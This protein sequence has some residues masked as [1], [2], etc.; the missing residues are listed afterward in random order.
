MPARTSG[1]T[2]SHP[3]NAI[4]AAIKA[5]ESAFQRARNLQ[6]KRAG[7]RRNEART[8]RLSKKGG[9][10]RK[11]GSI[12][13]RRELRGQATGFEKDANRRFKNSPQKVI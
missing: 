6:T 13:G 4:A 8:N 10:A 12:S 2:E 3:K 7:E 1:K 9:T 5:H 11:Y